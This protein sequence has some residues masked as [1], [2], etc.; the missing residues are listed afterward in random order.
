MILGHEAFSFFLAIVDMCVQVSPWT[1]AHGSWRYFLILSLVPAPS[2]YSK[3]V[4]ILNH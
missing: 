1:R 3:S 2:T 4:T